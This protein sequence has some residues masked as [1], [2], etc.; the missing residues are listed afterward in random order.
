MPL[1]CEF[2]ATEAMYDFQILMIDYYLQ[3]MLAQ[4]A[5]VSAQPVPM[6]AQGAQPAQPSFVE[7]EVT[8]GAKPE[9]PFIA[10]M[11]MG[12]PQYMTYYLYMLKFYAKY[13]LLTSTQSLAT[14]AAFRVAPAAATG[15]H[16]AHHLGL[17]QNGLAGLQQWVQIKFT[18]LYFDMYMIFSAPGL[19]APLSTDGP[20][21]VAANNFV[22]TEEPETRVESP[23]V[24]VPVVV[25]EV[26]VAA[27]VQAEPAKVQPRQSV[28]G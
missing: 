12:N 18:L 11:M 26:P 27:P 13:I 19:S 15:D 21:H 4:L 28:V 2:F 17:K 9:K 6:P 3:P 5:G 23:V 24:E 25:A 20:S 10:A 16:H 14:D 8:L 22:Q 1:L 7:E